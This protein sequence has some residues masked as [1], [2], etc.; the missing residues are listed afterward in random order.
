MN[1]TC[2]IASKSE[3]LN[4]DNGKEKVLYIEDYVQFSSVVEARKLTDKIYSHNA[5]FITEHDYKGYK[6]TWSWYS[7]VFQFCIKYFEIERLI[8]TIDVLD[9]QHLKIGNIPPQ[10]R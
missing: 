8:Q 9:A 5:D 6:I 1:Q 3:K 4:F 10:Y 7:D 2:I